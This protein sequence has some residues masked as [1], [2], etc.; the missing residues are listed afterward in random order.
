MSGICEGQASDWRIVCA[1]RYDI[2]WD[3]IIYSW[4]NNKATIAFSLFNDCNLWIYWCLQYQLYPDVQERV[5][6]F[7]SWWEVFYVSSLLSRSFALLRFNPN[8]SPPEEKYWCVSDQVKMFY[9]VKNQGHD[10]FMPTGTS[11]MSLVTSSST[12]RGW[13]FDV[14]RKPFYHFR[15]LDP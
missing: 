10:L 3:R 7:S 13:C 15:H 11:M 14:P 8:I 5:L 1:G 2:L 4:S 12:R 9:V 6:M